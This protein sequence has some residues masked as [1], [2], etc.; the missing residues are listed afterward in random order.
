[1]GRGRQKAKDAKIARQL[2]YTAAGTDLRA[3]ER[4]LTHGTAAAPVAPVAPVVEEL[5][6]DEFDYSRW[7]IDDE[8]EEDDEQA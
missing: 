4:E 5:D 6:E 2:K 8:D 7:E 1:M 3:L